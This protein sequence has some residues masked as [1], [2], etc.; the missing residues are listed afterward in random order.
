MTFLHFPSTRLCVAFYILY[1]RKDWKKGI[2]CIRRGGEISSF[3]LNV[4]VCV[5]CLC[6]VGPDTFKN[7]C[8]AADKILAINPNERTKQIDNQCVYPSLAWDWL[9][10]RRPHIG[11]SSW[12]WSSSCS[13]NKA[14]AA[15]P[16]IRFMPSRNWKLLAR[17]QN[18]SLDYYMPVI[19]KSINLKTLRSDEVRSRV[20]SKCRVVFT[21]SDNDCYYSDRQWSMVCLCPFFGL[22]C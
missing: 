13:A 10:W 8:R 7:L 6:V 2:Q 1:V 14:H 17:H 18:F 22:H 15:Y 4:P 19:H 5:L 21:R 3:H 11:R 9:T 20:I 12:R 16:R